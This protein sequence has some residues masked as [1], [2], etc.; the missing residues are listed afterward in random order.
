MPNSVSF[1]RASDYYDATRGLPPEVSERVTDS[2]LQLVG[3][4]PATQFLEVGVG[5]GRIAIPIVKRGFTYTGI[6][7][8]DN[9]LAKLRQNLADSSEHLTLLNAD[10]TNLPFPA[11]S[12]DVVLTVHVL[13]LIPDWQRALAEIRRVLKP[14][15]VYVYSHGSINAHPAEVPK[16]RKRAEIDQQWREI[17]SRYG[18][19]P[20]PHGA[21]AEE[22]MAKLTAQGARLETVVVAQWPGD[23]TIAEL[24]YRLEHRLYSNCWQIPEEIFR[25]AFGDLRAWVESHYRDLEQ[26]AVDPAEFKVVLVRDW[27]S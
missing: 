12:F 7:I 22:V 5:T 13:H 1:D 18:Y 16:E 10:A 8:S 17:L 14:G 25:P 3:V 24:L 11:A 20:K 15:G 2:I 9:M 6:D 23:L 27:A 26:L 21:K 4:T 19:D